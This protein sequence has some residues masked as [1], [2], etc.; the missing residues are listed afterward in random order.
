MAKR[1]P[2]TVKV[3]Q[4]VTFTA[5]K[6]ITMKEAFENAAAKLATALDMLRAELPLQGANKKALSE[7]AEAFRALIVPDEPEVVEVEAV[8]P[9]ATDTS[10]N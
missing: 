4:E 6:E 9:N 8:D 2:A 3:T 7:A 10:V 5:T 1:K